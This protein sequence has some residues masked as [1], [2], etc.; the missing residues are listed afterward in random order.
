V[1]G[2]AGDGDGDVD[3]DV[4]VMIRPE[5]LT[6]TRPGAGHLDAVVRDV[7]Y[8]GHDAVV[9]LAPADD[10]SQDPLRSRV[11]GVDAPA[12][13]ELVGVR[14][15]GGVRTFRRHTASIRPRRAGVP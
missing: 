12:I 6:L 14:V 3:V 8:F 10:E 7:A 2:A 1:H 11:L 15:T 5:Q 9:E 4:D 13:G